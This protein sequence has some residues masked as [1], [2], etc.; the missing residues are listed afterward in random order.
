[1][2]QTVLEAVNVSKRF[3]GTTALDSISVHFDE[4]KIYGLLGRNGAGKTTL[5]NIIT[6]RAF[7][8]GGEVRAFGESVVENPRVLPKICYMP[9]KNLFSRHNRVKDILH[10]ASVFYENFDKPYAD[11]LCERFA[12]DTRKQYQALSRGYESILRIVLGMASRAPITIFDEPVLGLD[13]AVREDFY[14]VLIDDFANFPRTLIISTHMIEESAEIFDDAVI[15]RNGRLVEQTSAE[16]LIENSHYISGKKDEV[17]KAA[18]GLNVVNRDIMAGSETA[19]VYGPLNEDK[20]REILEA[21]L[22]ITPVP[23]QKLFIYM[24]GR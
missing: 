13:A 10:F 18:A 3:G 17:E 19:A 12:L 20:Q 11:S 24:T 6:S 14:R 15:I 16:Q 22:E 8:Q 2:S 5:L 9:E 23:L 21:G 7:A 1:M 4:N